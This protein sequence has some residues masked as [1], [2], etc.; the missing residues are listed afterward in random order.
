MKLEIINNEKGSIELTTESSMSSYGIP[1]LRINYDGIK[2]DFGPADRIA[3][4]VKSGNKTIDPGALLRMPL[5][6]PECDYLAG[7]KACLS[8]ITSGSDIVFFWATWPGNEENEVQLNPARNEEEI[9]AARSF[10]RQNPN[11]KQI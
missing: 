3:F 7:V 6:I 8:G 9:F 5:T 10:L 11:G 4:R 1:V 2:G